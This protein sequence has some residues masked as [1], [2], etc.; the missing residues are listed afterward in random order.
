[1]MTDKE[2]AKT[3]EG[4]GS[5]HVGCPRC[6]NRDGDTLGTITM[7]VKDGPFGGEKIIGEQCMRCLHKWST[8][9]LPLDLKE[10]AQYQCRNVHQGPFLRQGGSSSARCNHCGAMCG[11]RELMA[12]YYATDGQIKWAR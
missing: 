12:V 4:L 11:D 10:R 5:P 6:N 8:D 2:F 9:G 1:M 7:Y 3:C